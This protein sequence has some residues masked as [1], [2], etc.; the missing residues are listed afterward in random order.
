MSSDADASGNPSG[1]NAS[2]WMEC[3]WPSSLRS[4]APMVTSV[5]ITRPLYNSDAN[6]LPS[7]K[8]LQQKCNL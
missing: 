2:E 3:E 6:C 5:R 4:R 1:E 7:E 8:R